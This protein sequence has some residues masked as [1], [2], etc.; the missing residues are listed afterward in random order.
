MGKNFWFRSTGDHTKSGSGGVLIGSA[1]VTPGTY[2]VTVGSGGTN[3]SGDC[4]AGVT[5]GGDGRG[6]NGGNSS[7]VRSGTINIVALGGGGGGS[8][9]APTGK[10][11]GSGGCVCCLCCVVLLFV[12]V[13]IGRAH[14]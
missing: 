14:V 8:Q 7:I 5:S 3:A 10:D 2:T 11:G 6:G 9:P 12:D 4:S 13:E 1:L